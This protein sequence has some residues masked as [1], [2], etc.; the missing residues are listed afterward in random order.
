[1]KG[2]G[3]KGELEHAC[4]SSQHVYSRYLKHGTSGDSVAELSSPIALSCEFHEVFG[5]CERAS[6]V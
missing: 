5:A 1:M 2:G 3:E 6:A 4:F